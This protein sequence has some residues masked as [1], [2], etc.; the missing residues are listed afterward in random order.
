LDDLQNQNDNLTRD[1]LKLQEFLEE[2]HDAVT[3]KD[4]FLTFS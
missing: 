4:F 2:L 1:E 3:A